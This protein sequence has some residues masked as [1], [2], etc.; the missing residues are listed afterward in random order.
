MAYYLNLATLFLHGGYDQVKKTRQQSLP[1][2]NR[3]VMAKKLLRL[4]GLLGPGRG[5][6][7]P[8]SAAICQLEKNLRFL[9]HKGAVR[10]AGGRIYFTDR[11][12]N[13]GHEGNGEVD[14]ITTLTNAVLRTAAPPKDYQ[15]RTLIFNA[16]RRS[17]PE[18]FVRRPDLGSVQAEYSGHLQATLTNPILH[19][20]ALDLAAAKVLHD[21]NDRGAIHSR[22]QTIRR[23]PQVM[24]Q[25]LRLGKALAKAR[26]GPI[27]N[28]RPTVRPDSPL[29]RSAALPNDGDPTLNYPGGPALSFVISDLHLTSEQHS[30][31]RDLLRF[32][33]LARELRAAVVHNGDYYDLFAYRSNILRVWQANHD[34][35]LAADTVPKVVQIPGNHDAWVKQPANARLITGNR[36]NV[37][38]LDQGYYFDGRVYVEHGHQADRHNQEDQR[39]GMYIVRAITWLEQRSFVRKYLPNLVRWIELGERG[40]FWLKS[41][42]TGRDEW[43][44]YK[45][46]AV[47]ARVRQVFSFAEAQ[48]QKMGLPPFSKEDPLI[49]VR[50]HDHGSGFFFTIE[51]MIKAVYHDDFLA[52][53]VRYFNS[54]SWKG[55]DADFLAI[56]YTQPDRVYVYP[57]VWKPTYDRFVAFR[58]Q[59]PPAGQTPLPTVSRAGG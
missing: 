51:E 8:N 2:L 42:M 18:L 13:L 39:R 28:L 59:P 35:M 25:V 16:L 41:L 33:S 17:Y 31:E 56:D 38:L 1:Y 43:R 3:M 48:R 6:W 46:D 9:E 14:I 27:L 50:G 20:E 29:F 22:V 26:K 37:R 36:P 49:Y 5:S 53:R 58:R 24:G 57:F 23:H 12:L 10:V 11:K 52:G 34:V 19:Q 44:G 7:K 54:G 55:S 47:V 32:Y 40:W 30:R 4:T 15:Q 45:R 21:L